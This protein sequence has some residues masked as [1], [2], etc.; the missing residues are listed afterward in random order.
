MW[1]D[2]SHRR[3]NL[4][5]LLP[6]A[7]EPNDDAAYPISIFGP[8][9]DLTPGEVFDAA[10]CLQRARNERGPLKGFRYSRRL[11]GIVSAAKAGRI[12][13]SAW[14]CHMA[15]KRGGRAMAEKHLELLREMAPLAWRRSVEVRRLRKRRED[16]DRARGGPV[17]SPPRRPRS[18]LES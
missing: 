3:G 14:G 7:C 10:R 2:T 1:A 12:D 5:W 18:F 16:Y 13:N 17:L 8:H 9:H 11:G 15:G 4:H 6:A